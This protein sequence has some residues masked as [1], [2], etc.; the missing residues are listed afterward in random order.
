MN[1]VVK[2]KLVQIMKASINSFSVKQHC[3][4]I[5][6]KYKIQFI[7]KEIMMSNIILK[8][9]FFIAL[10]FFFS[11]SPG[12]GRFRALRTERQ[13]NSI[14]DKKRIVVMKNPYRYRGFEKVYKE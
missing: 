9:L 13:Q 7:A 2:A 5:V 11:V 3:R 4:G 6:T 1:A 10:L 8:A 12:P 14:T